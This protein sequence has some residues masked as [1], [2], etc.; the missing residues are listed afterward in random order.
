MVV[1]PRGGGFRSRDSGRGRE[2]VVGIRGRCSGRWVSAAWWMEALG[3]AAGEVRKKGLRVR[4]FG[5]R[6]ERVFGSGGSWGVFFGGP[7]GKDRESGYVRRIDFGCL[8][9]GKIIWVVACELVA[10][11]ESGVFVWV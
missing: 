3:K 4:V 11:V 6:N 5:A 1:T 10:R 7:D 9:D 2:G 8:R